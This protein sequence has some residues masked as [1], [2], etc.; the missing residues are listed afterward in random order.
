[1]RVLCFI[2]ILHD[3]QFPWIPPYFRVLLAGMIGLYVTFHEQQECV[4][5][6]PSQSLAT[7]ARN[8]GLYRTSLSGPEVRQ[9]FKV[10][11]HQKPDVLLP[12]RRTFITWKNGEKNPKKKSKKK[13]FWKFF[14]WIF[15]GFFSPIFSSDKSPASGKENVRF[16][17]SPDFENL[18]DFRTEQWCPVE[19]YCK[20]KIKVFASPSIVN[21]QTGPACW[22]QI[23]DTMK[24]VAVKFCLF[25]QIAFKSIW[26]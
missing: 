20:Q 13:N 15:F 9:I 16:L 6:F 10:R 7:C 17:V 25:N 26:I 8:V 12:G 24:M 14:F 22:L 21:S 5:D 2:G 11:T 18:P 1:M 19:P 4:Y 23:H 3:S